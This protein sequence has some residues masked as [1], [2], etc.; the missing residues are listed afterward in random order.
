MY[1]SMSRSSL[2]V[3]SFP[4]LAALCLV[5]AASGRAQNADVNT[6]N[7]LLG[8]EN[9][10]SAFLTQGVSTFKAS[11][12]ASSTLLGS[13]ACKVGSAAAL[14]LIQTMLANENTRIARITDQ[15]KAQGGTPVSACTY[16]FTFKTADDFLRNAQTIGNL[17]VAAQNASLNA[18]NSPD[19]R[20]L[21]SSMLTVSSRQAAV[22]NLLTGLPAFTDP[23]DVAS[24]MGAIQ[25]LAGPFITTCT[26]PAPTTGSGPHN[27]T[28]ISRNLQLDAATVTSATGKIVS[29]AWTLLPGGGSASI[30]NGN[31][32]T[33]MVQFSSGYGTY[34]F[35]LKVT[36]DKGNSTIDTL[37][38]LYQGR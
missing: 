36:D 14:P 25:N 23:T 26:P 33:P 11:D 35:Q 13:N 34:L 17:T 31:S 29:Y 1:T 8:I 10:S 37:N 32:A 21:T 28:T 27:L 16:N 22:L 18:L 6:L 19:L 2:F 12:F 5:L 24:S 9:L 30:A 15:I 7:F 3:R 20:G 4:R 38:V